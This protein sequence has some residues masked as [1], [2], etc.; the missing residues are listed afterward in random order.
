[1]LAREVDHRTVFGHSAAW[2][3]ESAVVFPQLFAT[4]ADVKVAFWIECEVAAGEGSVRALGL[5][6]QFHMRLDSALVHQPPNHLGRAVTRI[7]D[8]ARRSDFELF[9]RAVEHRLG[10]ADFG[11]ANGRR[12]LDVHDHWMLQIDEVVVGIG[13]TGDGVGRSGVA[14]GR[15]GWRDRLRLDGRRPAEGRVVQDRQIFRDCATGGRIEI[16]DLADA[17]P[18]MRV[19]HDDAG[20]NGKS[21]ASHDPFLHAARATTVS[22]SLRR[23]S[24]SRNRPWRFLEKVE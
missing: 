11:L 1:M 23:R 7:G 3:G 2:L 8:Q 17:A 22:K 18:S 16:C 13:I 12:R 6:H 14:G 19:R 21:F 20:V 9:G 5:I 24:L 4:G 10:R 15:I